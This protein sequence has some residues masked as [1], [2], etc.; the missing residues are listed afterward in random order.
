VEAAIIDG[1]SVYK[2]FWVIIF[3]LLKPVITT[4]FILDFLGIW[5]DFLLP[6]LTISDS[7]KRTVTLAMYNFYGEYG[8]RWEMTFAG[9]TMAILPLVILYI[10][11]QRHI[12]SGIMV[13]AVKG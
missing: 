12:I 4:L 5:N 3:P 1:C 8:S 13:G 6:M 11:L 2:I 10:L 7:S 9:Y